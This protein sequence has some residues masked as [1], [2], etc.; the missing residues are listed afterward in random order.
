VARGVTLEAGA[1][2]ILDTQ[3]RELESGYFIA[4]GQVRTLYGAI[5]YDIF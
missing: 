5:H 3:Y 2:N 4:P 1:R